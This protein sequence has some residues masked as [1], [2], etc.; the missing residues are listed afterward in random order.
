MKVNYFS[1]WPNGG[2]DQVGQA[3]QG[4]LKKLGVDFNIIRVYEPPTD[5]MNDCDVIHC[6]YYRYYD[7]IREVAYRPVTAN[8][9][10]VSISDDSQTHLFLS[11][12]N[13]RE[14]VVDDVATLQNLGFHGFMNVHKIP[15]PMT[16]EKFHH[17]PPPEGEFTVG[18]F[19]NDYGYKRWETVVKAAK[20]A[21]VRCAAYVMPE[22]RKE[23]LLDPVTD[24]YANVHTLASATFVDTNSL[25]LREAL[26]CGRP[27]I[28][29]QNDGLGRVLREGVNGYW[30][31][32]TPPDL[33]EKI[34]LTKQ[35]YETLAAGA[36]TTQMESQEEIAKAYVR[37]WEK[38]L[39]EE[40]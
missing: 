25:P 30:H 10:H 29:T 19:C 23:Y 32:G 27:V 31:N 11:R 1:G 14:I 39:R 26:L 13:I 24:V 9:W 7:Y 18:V 3:L 6:G 33:A 8:V 12:S 37:M 16:V 2:I 15:L 28:S 21:G 40:E 34:L 5:E 17:L 4:S 36:R 20:L 38:V 35:N 22:N